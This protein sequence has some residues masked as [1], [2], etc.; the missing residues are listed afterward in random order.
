MKVIVW[1]EFI[2]EKTDERVKKI[3]P[4]G[5]HKNIASF[6]Q[7]DPEIETLTAT[8]EQAEHGLTEDRL[9]NTDVLI[10]WGHNA[11]DKVDNQVV[12]R[13]HKKVLEGMGFIALHSSHESKVFKKLLGTSGSLRWRDIG[14]RERIWNIEPS[15]PITKGIG[16]CIELPQTEMYGERFDIPTPDQLVFISWFQGGEVFRSGCC[17]ERGFGRIFYF[18]PGHETYP[19]FEMKDIQKVITN[20]VWWAAPRIRKQQEGRQ[21]VPL[22]K[23]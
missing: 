17:W 3:Y 22:E 21:G 10:W 2:H 1:N 7:K 5:M 23:I 15:H 8:L 14:E 12:E 4:H 16:D 6:L 20:A 9:A 11:H 13:V 19:I 18:R